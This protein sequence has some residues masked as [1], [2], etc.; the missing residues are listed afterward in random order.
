VEQNLLFRSGLWNGAATIVTRQRAVTP[1]LGERQHDKP[2]HWQ[3]RPPYIEAKALADKTTTNTKAKALAKKTTN[4][5]TKAP[6]KKTTNINSQGTGRKDHRH[7]QPRHRQKR[8]PTHNEAGPQ[9]DK[10]RGESLEP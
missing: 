2:R 7:Q 6:A 3:N 8:Q 5:K 10:I 9:D 4:I 1:Y